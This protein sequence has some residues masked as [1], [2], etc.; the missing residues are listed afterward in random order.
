MKNRA[1]RKQSLKQIAQTVKIGS[2]AKIY[3]LREV[4]KIS[5]KAKIYGVPRGGGNENHGVPF[6]IGPQAKFTTSGKWLEVAT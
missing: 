2:Q 4:V 3:D 1:D 5:P 6:K